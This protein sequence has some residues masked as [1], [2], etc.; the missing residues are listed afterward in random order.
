MPPLISLA[1]DGYTISEV[2]DIY[3]RRFSQ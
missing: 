3:G 2:I 1:I